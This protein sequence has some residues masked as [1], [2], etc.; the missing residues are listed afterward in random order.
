MI[1]GKFASLKW[2]KPK[3]PKFL[4]TDLAMLAAT[5][6]GRA[7][8]AAVELLGFPRAGKVTKTP[9]AQAVE[10]LQAAAEVEHA[11]LAEYLYAAYS[12]D[13]AGPCAALRDIMVQIAVEEM[14]H[15]ITVQNLLL[16]LGD[17]PYFDRESVPLNGKPAGQYPFPIRF[18]PLSGDV[19]AKYVTTESR[20][21]DNIEDSDLR[22]KL[23]PIFAQAEKATGSTINHV[24]LLYAKIF[25]L[26]QADDSPNPY[27][28]NL[29]VDQLPSRWH[30]PDK[31]FDKPL[32]GFDDPRQVKADIFQRVPVDPSH[33]AADDVYVIEIRARDQ[34]LFALA[35]I[36]AQGEGFQTIANSH[37][38][39]FLKAYDDFSGTLPTGVW[40]V[41][42]NPN[43]D[44]KPQSNP[45]AEASRITH[46]KANR[47]ARLF[48]F[49]YQLL[50]LKLWL[51][52]WTDPAVSGPLGRDNLFKSALKEMR[53][54]I[55]KLAGQLLP[56]MDLKEVGNNK[57]KAG[58]PFGL[59]NNA[60]PRTEQSVKARMKKLLA[61]TENLAAEILQLPAP[62][63]PTDEEKGVLTAIPKGDKLLRDALAGV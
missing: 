30:I 43:T 57:R 55:A 45:A 6:I 14:G 42:A 31:A 13:P 21:L 5:P 15:L 35:Q 50:L 36:A 25:W 3:K 2:V 51:G 40:P 33:P 38:A 53:A 4:S 27:W 32:K 61:D 22:K 41:P 47:W 10:L 63:A 60:L 54:Y 62:D 7:V 12:I 19:L 49:R 34:A 44:S 17:N 20:P 37:F 59:P 46:P 9:Q 11:L 26:F 18:E 52:V 16:A 56:G 8:R 28:P 24:G 1:G 39:R 58:A 48:D 23:A 29:P